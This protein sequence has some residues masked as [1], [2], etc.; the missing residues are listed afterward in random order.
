MQ[1]EA[2]RQETERTWKP[3]AAGIL[4]V[5]LGAIFLI[6]GIVSLPLLGWI[7]VTTVPFYLLLGPLVI[8]PGI[9][10]VVGGIYALRRRRWG[11]A[12]AGSIFSLLNGVILG[13]YGIIFLIGFFWGFVD[14]PGAHFEL[15]D[16]TSLGIYIIIGLTIFWILGLLAL[17]FVIRGRR[18][19]R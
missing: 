14:N 2:G 9:M 13:I 18:E 7:A 19:F 15:S 6:P 12:L 1:E 4:S 11:L 16:F 3:K 5:I 10:P 8:I 17:V